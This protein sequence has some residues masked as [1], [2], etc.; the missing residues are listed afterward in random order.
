MVTH[1]AFQFMTSIQNLHLDNVAGLGTFLSLGLIKTDLLA[2][3]KGFK[4]FILDLGKMD[5]YVGTTLLLDE[6]KTFS[7]VEPFYCA[8]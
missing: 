7:V 6:T 2:F 4:A 1:G 8:F 3:F 5:E